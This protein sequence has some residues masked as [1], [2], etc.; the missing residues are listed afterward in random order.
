MRIDWKGNRRKMAQPGVLLFGGSFNPIHHGHLIVARAVAEEL[1]I[2]RVLLIPSA[3]PPHKQD[4]ELAPAEDRRAMVE[5]AVAGEPVFAVD[6]RELRRDGPSYTIDTIDAFRAELTEGTTVYWLIGGD[7]LPEL[8]LWH[9]ARE[10]LDRC[11]VVTA[12]RPGYETPNLSVL[13]PTLR[14]DQIAQLRAHVLPTPRIDISAT[15][16][17]ARVRAGQS[18]RYLVPRAVAQ[19]ILER[20]LYR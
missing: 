6:D 3:Q 9:R 13:E 18:I 11:T 10:L 2:E 19:Y 16:I 5:R 7:T 12:V 14:P 15:D 20:S 17:R 4:Q 8:H 1:G